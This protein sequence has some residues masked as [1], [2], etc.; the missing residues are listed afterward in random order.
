MVEEKEDSKQK[1]LKLGSVGKG[2]QNVVSGEFLSKEGVLKNLPFLLFVAFLMVVYIGY[3]YYVDNT[4]REIAAEER[5][6]DKLYSDLQSLMEL[7]DRESLR[8]KVAQEVS[9]VGLFESKDP[10]RVV[11]VDSTFYGESVD[12]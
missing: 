11:W 10:P 4:V 3:G 12:E 5:E 2:F 8:S 9:D 7:Y 6:G 1:R